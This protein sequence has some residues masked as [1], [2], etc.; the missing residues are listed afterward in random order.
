[1][2]KAREVPIARG[3]SRLRANDVADRERLFNV[4]RLQRLRRSQRN[5]DI[6][7]A[8]AGEHIGSSQPVRMLGLLRIQ[9]LVGNAR[10][11]KLRDE[12][13][14][15]GVANQP[16]HKGFNRKRQGNNKQN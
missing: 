9:L 3:V 16:H 15:A 7:S 13:G 5:R 10:R 4:R 2:P 12:G 6:I 1:M 8:T 14:R 11:G